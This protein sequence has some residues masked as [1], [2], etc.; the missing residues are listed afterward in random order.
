LRPIGISGTLESDEFV[1]QLAD[2]DDNKLSD[3]DE[4]NNADIYLLA[5]WMDNCYNSSALAT[6]LII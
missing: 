2:T 3:T 6:Y 5:L 1:E 4:S